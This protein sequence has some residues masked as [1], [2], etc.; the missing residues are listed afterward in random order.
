MA[1]VVGRFE[2]GVVHD[3]DEVRSH[4]LDRRHGYLG[5][6]PGATLVEGVDG[7]PL[8]QRPTVGIPPLTRTVQPGT[9]D[10]RRAST[11]FLPIKINSVAHNHWHWTVSLTFVC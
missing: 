9:E 8:G 7:E 5:R 10:Q 6:S 4:L 11:N 3:R 2:T 1:G